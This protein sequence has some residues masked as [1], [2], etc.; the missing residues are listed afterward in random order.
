MKKTKQVPDKG[1]IPNKY[2]I[3]E[4]KPKQIPEN[5]RKDQ[6]GQERTNIYQT[7]ERK[8]EQVPDNGKKT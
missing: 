5:K 4:G 1:N 6:H 3:R 7:R 8:T 2:K